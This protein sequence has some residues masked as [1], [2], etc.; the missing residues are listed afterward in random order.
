MTSFI[1]WVAVDERAPSAVY[2]ASES[3]LSNNTWH[4]DFGRKLFA[5][6][7][8]PDIFG[9]VG[10]VLFPSQILSQVIDLIDV[11]VLF[12]PDDN[13]DQKL[14]KIK[15]FLYQVASGYANLTDVY[16]YYC[17]RL[18]RG[19]KSS[20]QSTFRLY[21]I[22]FRNNQWLSERIGMPMKSGPIKIDGSGRKHVENA[23]KEWEQSSHK[24]TSRSM[25][26][27]FCDAIEITKDVRSGGAPQLVGVHR[28][29]PAKYFGIVHKNKRY[30]LGLPV[31]NPENANNI[32]WFNEIFEI[33][34]GETKKRQKG[35]KRHQDI[36]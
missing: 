4:W 29:G 32:N 8:Y 5:S 22:Y 10:D 17:S 21:R 13:V 34:N 20:L 26:S 33:T 28:K 15:F 7:T 14:D 11:G 12:K 23:I 9:Y 19:G 36:D 18:D 16:I 35:V 24:D 2:F 6:Q 31:A 30:F 25:F 3:R 1:A 27:A